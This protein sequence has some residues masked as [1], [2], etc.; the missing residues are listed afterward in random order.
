MDKF[1]D[2]GF[3]EKSTIT[4]EGINNHNGSPAKSVSKSRNI[5]DSSKMLNHLSPS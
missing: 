3:G 5:N 1:L 2:S 4:A